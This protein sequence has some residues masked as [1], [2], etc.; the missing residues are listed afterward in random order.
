MKVPRIGER[1]E[2]V[3]WSLENRACDQ[4]G[5]LEG[6]ANRC[7]ATR[8]IKL[9]IKTNIESTPSQRFGP[10]RVCSPGRHQPLPELYITGI[11]ICCARRT[12][13]QP[14]GTA[15]PV[16]PALHFNLDG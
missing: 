11:K 12:G 8:G 7:G 10:N 9:V 5:L 13:I 2:K 3:S 15:H 1:L 16:A 4:V 6:I 14:G